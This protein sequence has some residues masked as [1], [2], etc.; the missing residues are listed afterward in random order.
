MKLISQLDLA[1]RNLW[2][3]R[4]R[5]LVTIF[6]LA[7]G[8]TAL[9]LFA[10]YTLAVYT[11][12]SNAAIH[13]ELLGHLTINHK[14]WEVQGKLNPQKYLL[15]VQEI[16]KVRE[17]V[18][19]TMP[20][21]LVVPKLSVS[22]LMSNGH[23]STIFVATGIAPTDLD[24]LR[25]PFRHV[26]GALSE[27]KPSG[28][29]LAQGLADILGFKNGS[30][31]SLLTNTIRGQVN[32]ADAD[33]TDTVD[34][35]NVSTNDKLLL[36]PLMMAQ[37]LLDAPGRAEILTLLW[38]P[39][40]TANA[41]AGGNIATLRA[42]DEATTN[43]LR[44]QLQAGFRQQGLDLEVRTWQQMSAFF[45]QVKGMYDMI[46]TLMLI[47]VLTIVVFSIANAMSMA[48]VE[49]TREIG[50]LRAIGMR[51]AGIA[52]LFVSEALVL[53]VVG[54]V[55]SLLLTAAIR[56]YVNGADIR[57]I[58]PGNTTSVPIYIGFDLARTAA[59]A[60]L[61]SVLAVIAAYLPALRAARQPVI[62][63][64]GHV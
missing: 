22:G 7:F 38:T 62:E 6:S 52:G 15:T 19:Q 54:I 5:S 16:A 30:S 31:A 63:S 25:G 39:P 41:A 48:V 53:V 21:S 3:N 8:F 35:G 37:N 10:G 36:M 1:S 55:I 33:V 13:G 45:R 61:L 14:G 40:G 50:T 64:L 58:P 9:T 42:P 51:R 2:R 18:Q 12:L 32:A 43:A 4:R 34:T 44:A 57:Y 26:P 24:A 56:G 59:A 49:R 47:V 28:I 29:T 20:G 17:V 60:A 27:Q 11:A 23:N 46:F